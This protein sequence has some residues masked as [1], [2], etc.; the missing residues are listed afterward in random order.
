VLKSREKRRK[1]NVM[2][3]HK[4]KA[5]KGLEGTVLFIK[6][7][8]KENDINLLNCIHTHTHIHML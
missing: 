4:K 5:K 8:V 6:I 1:M 3:P 2:I 7:I